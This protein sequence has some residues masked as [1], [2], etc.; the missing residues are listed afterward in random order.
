MIADKD[1]GTQTAVGQDTADGGHTIHIPCTRVFTVHQFQNPVTAALHRK[2]DVAADIGVIRDDLKGLIT[3]V[4]GMGGSET[5]THA[6][7]G[8]RH[9]TEQLWEIYL[10]HGMSEN[11]GCYNWLDR[12]DTW[13]E[14]CAIVDAYIVATQLWR[15][16]GEAR[17]RDMAEKGFDASQCV[18]CGACEAACPQHLDIIDSLARAWKDL[19]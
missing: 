13:T 6:W 12:F 8:L 2:M 4:L 5:H 7:N 17:Y 14:P 1:I 10:R 18:R 16:T 19:N 11:Y 9:T 15:L 3:H